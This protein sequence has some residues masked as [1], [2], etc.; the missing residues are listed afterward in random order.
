[1]RG[2]RSF[3]LIIGAA[4]ALNACGGSDVT[5]QVLGEGADG[6]IP[7]ANLEVFFYPF[8]RDSVFDA[9]D[10]VKACV[11]IY[12]AMLPEIRV[13][14]ARMR[15]AALAGFATATDLADYLVRNNLAREIDQAEMLDLVARSKEMGLVLSADNVQQT[16][17]RG[18][19]KPL[20]VVEMP[21]IRQA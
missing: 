13:D 6:P 18:T 2:K 3:F 11:E 21:E 7:Q 1:M 4:V 14:R 5:V 12:A 16:T 19:Q 10:T 17:F 15:G 20:S 9:L 8:D